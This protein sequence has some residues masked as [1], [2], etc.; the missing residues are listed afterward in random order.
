MF[1]I[2]KNHGTNKNVERCEIAI[3][4]GPSGDSSQAT[5]SDTDQLSSILIIR[6]HCKFG[7]KK[8]HRLSLS[9]PP[10]HLAPNL[11]IS[12]TQSKVVA[13]PKAIKDLIDHFTMT[14]QKGARTTGSRLIW[15]WAGEEVTVKSAAGLLGGPAGKSWSLI[16][17]GA[18]TEIK[19]R[20]QTAISLH[21]SLLK[22]MNS[23]N[24]TSRRLPC[25]SPSNRKSLLW[26][27]DCQWNANIL[28]RSYFLPQAAITL[29]ENLSQQL[30]L[31]FSA[32]AAPLSITIESDAHESL[33][34]IATRES[35]QTPSSAPP[36]QTS[37]NTAKG[38]QR[39]GQEDA[40]LQGKTKPMKV[41]AEVA[42]P[43]N[44]SFR[45]PASSASSRTREPS[46]AFEEPERRS[47]AA[48]SSSSRTG[49]SVTAR[50]TEPT[51][52]QSVRFDLSKN[53]R[54]LFHA[55]SPSVGGSQRNADNFQQLSQADQEVIRASGLGLESMTPAEIAAML[56][57]DD[58]D[59][60]AEVG[61]G[62]VAD[63]AREL[64]KPTAPQWMA[65]NDG[66][67]RSF[68]FEPALSEEERMEM[69][70]DPLAGQDG[71]A[72]DSFM[73]LTQ[74]DVTA[75]RSKQKV[76]TEYPNSRLAH[77]H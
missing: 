18:C 43:Q 60:D 1:A 70:F 54:P 16:S 26:V 50:G 5:G 76:R 40:E 73:P 20:A 53:S 19:R 30:H 61:V 4:P 62:A 22:P 7:I 24:M 72:E 2:L 67:S 69:E 17:F 35:G 46:I 28:K 48:A 8:T 58:L 21:R 23:I 37:R 57:D 47:S 64:T 51:T 31:S 44:S 74:F 77:Y 55:A 59:L 9:P 6:L 66:Q 49:D 39:G 65:N 33:F 41:V 11:P 25:V 15:E 12:S 3:L 14:K 27:M 10:P 52:P 42:R 63:R 56:D 71:D 34:V 36:A 45:Q 13:G 68:Q 75:R 29:A 32:A 38:K